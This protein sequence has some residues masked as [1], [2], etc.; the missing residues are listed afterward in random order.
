MG[1][2]RRISLRKNKA[3]VGSELEVLVEGPSEDSEL[4]MAGLRQFAADGTYPAP[5]W[6]D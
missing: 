2:Q 5:L 3:L 4:V 1:I 6:A